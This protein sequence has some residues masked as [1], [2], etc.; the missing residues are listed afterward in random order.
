MYSH[1]EVQK[2]QP[3][4]IGRRKRRLVSCFSRAHKKRKS[5]LNSHDSGI[6]REEKSH[7]STLGRRAQ[8]RPTKFKI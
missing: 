1:L 5:L 6:D 3:P 7:T 4:R 8:K 2:K